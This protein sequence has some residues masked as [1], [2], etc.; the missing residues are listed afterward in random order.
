LKV[1]FYFLEYV[2]VFLTGHLSTIITCNV[3][4]LSMLCG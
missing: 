2:P 1:E 3:E 4:N